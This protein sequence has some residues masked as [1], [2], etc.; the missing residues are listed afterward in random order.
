[1]GALIGASTAAS[2]A[3]TWRPRGAA[4]AQAAMR[5]L[6]ASP[7]PEMAMRAMYVYTVGYSAVDKAPVD[8]LKSFFDPREAISYANSFA[9]MNWMFYVAVFDPAN[10]KWPNPFMEYS[11]YLP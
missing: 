11:P 3:S 10:S 1:M 5:E 9:G 2:I 8:H 6:Q 7:V 4:A